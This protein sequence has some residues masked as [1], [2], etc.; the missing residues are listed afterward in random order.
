MATAQDAMIAGGQE[1]PAGNI[2]ALVLMLA[3]AVLLNYVDRGAI[4]IAA[5]LMK[6]E[7]GLSA[8][9]FGIAVSAFFW[10]YAPLTIVVGWLCDRLCVYRMFALGVALWSLA[11][12]FTGWVGMVGWING[13]ALLLGLRLVL[14][15][16]ESIAFPGS[17]KIFAAEVPA[18]HRGLANASIASALGFGPTIGTV[19]GGLI[20]GAW[21]WRPIF[22][23]FGAVTLLWL[24]LWHGIAAPY[25]SSR[26]A[27]P[28]HDPAPVR[29][30][31]RNR[32]MWAHGAAHFCGNYGFYFTLTWTPLYLIQARGLSI[33]EMTAVSTVG[34]LAP[35]LAPFMGRWS[36]H[37]IT[38]GADEDRVRR[39]I[40]IAGLVGA[41]VVLIGTAFS[42]TIPA[43]VAWATLGGICT[44]GTATNVFAI[45][46]IFGGRRA[47]GAWVGVQNAMGNLSGIVA[48]LI[49]GVLVDRT[50]GFTAA[51]LVAA[52]L[53]GFSAVIWAWIMPAIVEQD[54]SNR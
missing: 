48:P 38:R 36:D 27:Q 7:L 34:F 29:A 42:H 46:Q 32:A 15:L 19:L 12:M 31:M 21:G 1:R 25:R 53:V 28:V 35:V 20:L 16:G 40:M 13:F 5:P 2:V 4:G 17:S 44:A 30:I 45:G 51:F 6:S 49:T 47:A 54:F 37:L 3:L 22:W 43:L 23:I 50:G 24:V 41:T 8:T 26:L 52:A 14:V 10:V 9:T 18:Q 11:T 33:G 39:T